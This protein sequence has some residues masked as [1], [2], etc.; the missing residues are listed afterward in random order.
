[1]VE[2]TRLETWFE[3]DRARVALYDGDELLI[4]WLDEAFYQEVEDGFLSD[5]GFILGKLLN[6]THLHQSAVERY[7]DFYPQKNLTF[8]PTEYEE[9]DENDVV[10]VVIEVHGL[11]WD[12]VYRMRA[13]V[14]HITFGLPLLADERI[15][16]R[17]GYTGNDFDDGA[18]LMV[19]KEYKEFVLAYLNMYNT[20]TH[21]KKEEHGY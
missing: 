4:E 20:V 1:M 19:L 13:A 17:G 10:F 3:R 9:V 2:N 8:K 16:V 7:K 6:T 21:V 15:Y 18:I 5:K 12:M 11:T 14:E